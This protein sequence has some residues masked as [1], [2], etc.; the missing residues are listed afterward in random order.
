LLSGV[1][2]ELDN[3]YSFSE[4]LDSVGASAELQAALE[5]AV[6]RILSVIFKLGL[7]DDP[8]V[9]PEEAER[10]SRCKEHLAMSLKA[11]EESIVL[12]KNKD[13]I[14]PLDKAEYKKI[15]VIGPH[16]NDMHYGGYSHKDT[17]NGIT[18]YEG[19]KD[20]VGDAVDVL[21]A[22]GC[23]IH[24]G[25]GH[26]LDGVDEF[27]LS[28]PTKNRRRIREAVQTAKQSDLVILAVGSTAVT[29]GEF[30]GYRHSL[31]LFGQQ[32][33]LVKAVI[34]TNVPV[35]VCLVNGR[36]LT[37]NYIDRE[38]DAVLETWYLGEQA[39]VALSRTLFG[40]VNPR[41]K[42]TLTFPRSTG[43]LPAYYSKK[44]SGIHDYLA[45]ENEPLYP[46]GYGLSYTTF[47]YSNLSIKKNRLI[48][49]ESTTVRFTL[50]NT[51]RRE[52]EEIVQLYIRDR[53]SSVT[54]PVKELKGFKKVNLE[55]GET[56][57]VE[58]QLSTDDLKYYNRDMEYVVEPGEFEIM[59]GASSEDIKLRGVVIVTD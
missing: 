58:F 33:D 22:K 57:T 55:P 26:W 18:F 45:E 48:D 30:I 1:D 10:V 50:G 37:I 12:L 5:K 2:M 16:A 20:Y 31:D 42:L 3:P 43:H 25:S 49:G 34:E 23:N 17:A 47:D 46:F 7:F 35:I 8:Y 4:L 56:K 19:I 11:A 9:E 6:R 38:A 40:D 53:I 39:G 28:D 13:N 14:L 44:P 51:G 36:P 54:R 41:G 24:K 59:I 52:G 27:E 21:Y 15:A 32:N 29:C